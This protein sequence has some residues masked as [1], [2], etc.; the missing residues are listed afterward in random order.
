MR[1]SLA[2]ISTGC[3]SSILNQLQ[4]NYRA[5]IYQRSWE[6]VEMEDNSSKFRTQ[7]FEIHRNIYRPSVEDSLPL[8]AKAKRNTTQ[9]TS[10]L[11]AMIEGEMLP[12]HNG[13]TTMMTGTPITKFLKSKGAD[14]SASVVSRMKQAIDERL[15]GVLAETA[16]AYLDELERCHWVKYAFNEKFQLPTFDEITSNLSEQANSWMGTELSSAKP[17][18]V[19]NCYFIKLSELM[20]E[21]R[22]LAGNW[23]KRAEKKVWSRNYSKL[24]K[25][26][27]LQMECAILLH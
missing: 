14:V 24:A 23:I 3:N 2:R 17:L 16:A 20:S 13:S 10:K 12:V 8:P 21:K 7:S 22:Q 6:I 4:S 1:N 5:R 18:D 15:H 19:F 26:E 11:T 25:I 27:Q 9:T